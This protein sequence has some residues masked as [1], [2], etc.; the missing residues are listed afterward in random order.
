MGLKVGA[1]VPHFGNEWMGPHLT[2]C[3][4]GPGGILIYPTAWPQYTNVIDRQTGQ[5][6]N[7]PIA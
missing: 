1:A 6:D 3:R 5:T 4:F 7:G 2:K